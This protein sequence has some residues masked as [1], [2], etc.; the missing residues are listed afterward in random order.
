MAD[1]GVNIEAVLADSKTDEN[2]C[3]ANRYRHAHKYYQ[4]V[5]EASKQGGQGK[6]KFDQYEEECHKKRTRL[7]HILPR[8]TGI[9][10]AISLWKHVLLQA[11]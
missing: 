5:G 8:L 10:D 11:T 1:L 4:R 9:I 2:H 6:G 3:P 7:L